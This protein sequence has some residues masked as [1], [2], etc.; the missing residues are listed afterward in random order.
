MKKIISLL[1]I[2]SLFF[3]VNI[4]AE[5]KNDPDY[6]KFYS[7]CLKYNGGDDSKKSAEF[8]EKYNQAVKYFFEDKDYKKAYKIFKDIIKKDSDKQRIC[9]AK[10]VLFEMYLKGLYVEKDYDKAF[11]LGKE[12]IKENDSSY[13]L[14]AKTLGI[15]GEMSFTYI[16]SDMEFDEGLSL[17]KQSASLG[18]EYAIK[19]LN[20]I[21]SKGITKDNLGEKIYGLKDLILFP[22]KEK[23]IMRTVNLIEVVQVFSPN[24]AVAGMGYMPD[25]EIVLFI[26][27]PDDKFYERQNIRIPPGKKIKQVGTCRVKC[28]LKKQGFDGATKIIPAVI[29]K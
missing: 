3:S 22:K 1:L 24:V 23:K 16:G 11:S 8:K 26:G 9:I 17:I 6:E 13:P 18:D 19:V 10:S 2:L 15:V 21:E 29:I 7:V 25:G 20:K 14:Y 12:I 5:D 27:N 4:F 28:K